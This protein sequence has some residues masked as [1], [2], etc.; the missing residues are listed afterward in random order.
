MFPV[1]TK[2]KSRRFQ[3]PQSGLQGA[4]EKLCFRDGLEWMVGLTVEII[5]RF[6]IIRRSADAA[7]YE[8]KGS[9]TNKGCCDRLLQT[10]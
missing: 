2:T 9:K 8:I 3:I 1:H 7:W 6:Q 4:F 10:L 5:L